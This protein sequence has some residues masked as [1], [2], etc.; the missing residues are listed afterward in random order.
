MAGRH[1]GNQA[2]VLSINIDWPI[3]IKETEFFRRIKEIPKG[4]GYGFLSR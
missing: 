4:K 1:T 3:Q 2:L